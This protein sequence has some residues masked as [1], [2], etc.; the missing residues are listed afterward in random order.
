MEKIILIALSAIFI[1][2]VIIYSWFNRD[3]D[4]VVLTL[5]TA[6][7]IGAVGFIAKE[8]ISNKLEKFSKEIP[9]AVFYGFPDYMP[10]KIQ[11]PY[12]Y[13][14]EL[15]MQSIDPKDIPVNDLN[16]VD[17][18]FAGDKYFDAIQFA[19]ISTIFHGFEKSWNIK[20]TQTRTPHGQS[21]SW[22]NIKE[23]GGVI[24]ASEFLNNLSDNYFVK[25][26]LHNNLELFGGKAMFPPNTKVEVSSE[27]INYR[28]LRISFTNRYITLIIKIWQSE[29]SVGVGEYKKLLGLSNE[30]NPLTSSYDDKYG[31]AV[32]L[33][34]VS[35]EQNYWLNGHPE[36][37]KYRNWAN[38]ITNL[39]NNKF[40]YEHIREEHLIKFQLYGSAEIIRSNNA[41]EFE[42]VVKKSIAQL[43]NRREKKN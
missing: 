22:R 25:L 4:R 19:V 12:S 20:T 10:L 7:T 37:Q 14:L 32:Y 41:F 24:T 6:M 8:S 15:C 5:M 26:G 13:D 11:L 3:S 9:V 43:K 23:E 16:R 2:V 29:S 30:L 38:S 34:E 27:E 1:G 28:N 40:N 39:I 18:D 42:S 36:M 35:A 21:L 31:N 17:L 33:I